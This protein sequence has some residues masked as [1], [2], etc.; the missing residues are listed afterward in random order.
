[1][2]VKRVWEDVCH[3]SSINMIQLHQR[4]ASPL[5]SRRTCRSCTVFVA[6]ATFLHVDVRVRNHISIHAV[7]VDSAIA[8]AQLLTAGARM[9]QT[10]CQFR[11]FCESVAGSF[12][13]W[14]IDLLVR[15][16]ALVLNKDFL[17]N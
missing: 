1:M 2:I 11:V 16:T 3:S 9:L 12:T 6:T 4:E 15:F 13:I 10:R 8:V 7:K 17:G 14:H 5:A